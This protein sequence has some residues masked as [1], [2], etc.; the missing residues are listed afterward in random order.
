MGCYLCHWDVWHAANCGGRLIAICLYTSTC[1]GCLFSGCRS[2]YCVRDVGGCLFIFHYLFIC[3]IVRRCFARWSAVLGRR[4]VCAI[5]RHAVRC[6]YWENSGSV[7]Q[8]FNLT[9]KYFCRD[10]GGR[11]RYA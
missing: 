4:T 2:F 10:A 5:W 1:E 8:M 11:K 7:E 6:A 3:I 9:A